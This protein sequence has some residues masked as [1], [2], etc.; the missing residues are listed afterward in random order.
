MALLASAAVFVSLMNIDSRRASLLDGQGL[1]SDDVT[2]TL[3]FEYET[4]A[5]FIFDSVQGLLK[6]WPNSYA[7]NGHSIVAGTV[8]PATVLYHAKH[9]PGPPK[10]P[11]FFAFDAY[12]TLLTEQCLR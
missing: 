4:V 5:P 6:Q 2:S 9:A 1:S 8:P 7:P 11:T 12:V 3:S 10:K